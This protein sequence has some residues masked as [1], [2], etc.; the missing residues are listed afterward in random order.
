MTRKGDG[1]APSEG[2][3]EGPDQQMGEIGG[4]QEV[5]GPGLRNGVAEGFEQGQAGE[6]DGEKAHYAPDDGVPEPIVLVI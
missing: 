1:L 6:P 3:I 4:H 5:D 2:E